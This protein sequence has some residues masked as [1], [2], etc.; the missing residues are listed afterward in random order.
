MDDDRLHGSSPSV[1]QLV[2]DL[3]LFTTRCAMRS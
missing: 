3:L 2:V 1:Y